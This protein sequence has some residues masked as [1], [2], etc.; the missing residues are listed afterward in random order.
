MPSDV[1]SIDVAIIGA[2]PAG[3]MAADILSSQG[4]KADIFDAMPTA[5]RKFLMAGK[6]GLNISHS[7]P[8][9]KLLARFGD[10]E[11]M[12]APAL[13]AFNA[14]D[15]EK[16][17]AELGIESF[18]GSSGRIFPKAMK[19]APLL[20]AWLK[21][22]SDNGATLHTRHRWTGWDDD[23][24]LVFSVASENIHYRSK[25]TVLALGGGSWSRLGSDAAWVDTLTT[26]GVTVN[27]L[28]PANCG[29]D[30]TWSEHF[31]SRCEGEPVA[32]VILSHQDQT[33]K[34]SFVVTKNGIEGG[35]VY[36]ISAA[37]RDGVD[38]NGSTM[39]MVDLTPDKSAEQLQRALSS[40][41][42]RKS[43]SN[44]MRRTT[45]IHGVKAQLLRECLPNETFDDM[46][47]LARAIK[48]VPIKIERPRPIDEAISTAGGVSFDAMDENFKLKAIEN[49]YCIGEMMDWEAPTG[50]Y[51]ITAC[52][53][54]GHHVGN[55]IAKKFLKQ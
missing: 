6:S 38:A 15:I 49:T 26:K 39:L 3:L 37:L 36:M 25:A 34:G 17:M 11:K 53:A 7:E 32:N 19:T 45:G 35:A 5:G 42:G 8:L 28:K 47:A 14:S 1:K 29:F 44:H 52:M 16:F 10:K 51:L 50:G 24:S 43:L 21:R 54:T 46:P 22:L 27:P 31:L 23:G 13:N 40:S 48:G 41:R 33:S 55:A 2:G 4:I 12:L 20:R 18:V 9:D 30:V